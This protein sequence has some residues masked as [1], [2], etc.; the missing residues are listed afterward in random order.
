MGDLTL[1]DVHLEIDGAITVTQ[2]HA[3]AT[4][5]RR[6]VLDAHHVLDVMTHVDPVEAQGEGKPKRVA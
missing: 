2:G 4:D 6:R 1:V 5:A 3:I